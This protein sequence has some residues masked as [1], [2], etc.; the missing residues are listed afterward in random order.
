MEYEELAFWINRAWETGCTHLAIMY[1]S[2]HEHTYP[3][4]VLPRESTK[5]AVKRKEKI[6]HALIELFDIREELGI[7]KVKLNNHYFRRRLNAQTI[8]RRT[9]RAG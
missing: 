1:D 4:Y 3:L 9:Q 5:G 7:P 2:T 8:R 6:G